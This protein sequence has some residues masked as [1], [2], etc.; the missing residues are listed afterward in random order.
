MDS[1][2]NEQDTDDDIVDGFSEII[3]DQFMENPLSISDYDYDSHIVSLLIEHFEEVIDEDMIYDIYTNKKKEIYKNIGFPLRSYE[4]TYITEGTN[5]TQE[6][7]DYLL[8]IPQPD[9]RTK[10][11]YE[12]RH[13]HITASNAWKCLG[14][15]S[16]VNQIILEKLTPLNIEKYKP[17]LND[18]PMT[19]GQRF[20]DISI[21]FYEN[22]YNVKVDDL[23]CIEH[24]KYTFLAASPDGIITSKNNNSRLLEIKNV[25]SRKIT[26]IPK[27]DYW[28][29]MQLQMEVCDIDECDFLETKFIEYEGFSEFKCDINETNKGII[30]MFVKNSEIPLYEYSELYKNIE[31]IEK[32]MDEKMDYYE[33]IENITWFKNIY[34]KMEEFS[35]I[36]VKRNKIW[37]ENAISKIKDVWEIIVSERENDCKNIDNYKPKKRIKVE[38]KDQ[39]DQQ[40]IVTDVVT[41]NIIDPNIEVL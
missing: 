33:K 41:N 6:K 34:W 19:W 7:C 25:V 37:F 21:M 35:C 20:E 15:P 2:M 28:M 31:D 1:S 39:I 27:R 13:N 9:Q 11:W 24:Q 5:N 17:S 32:W 36:M 14:T 3:K 16:S 22:K 8:N 26:K 30:M 10:E 38:K 18:N 12:F 29:Q 4:Y 23:G 40:N